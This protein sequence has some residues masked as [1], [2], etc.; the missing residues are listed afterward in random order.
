MEPRLRQGEE[1][2]PP[3]TVTMGGQWCIHCNTESGGYPHAPDCPGPCYGEGR[4]RHLA[5]AVCYHNR[6][7]PELPPC[8][9]EGLYTGV[10]VGNLTDTWTWC[11][12]HAPPDRVPIG[13]PRRVSEDEHPYGTLPPTTKEMARA[14]HVPQPDCD[15]LCRM[16]GDV[17]SHPCHV[18]FPPGMR[19]TP[20]FIFPAPGVSGERLP[21]NFTVFEH[22][23]LRPV[24]EG[25]H[26]LMQAAFRPDTGTFWR[27]ILLYGAQRMRASATTL[28]EMDRLLRLTRA[29]RSRRVDG[30]VGWRREGRASSGAVTVVCNVCDRTLGSF[31]R[32]GRPPVAVL[33]ASWNHV[34]AEHLPVPKA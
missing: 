6:F 24:P 32:R 26:Y 4:C 31:D 23:H 8:P 16:E 11:T 1:R 28:G 7:S 34:L 22:P 17:S 29:S 20:G 15:R 18:C 9:N 10:P 19:G 2:A 33:E 13:S 30:V 25:V 21:V 27:M 12:E 3:I 5:R 14:L